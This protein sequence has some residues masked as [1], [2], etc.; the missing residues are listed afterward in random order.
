MVA[1]FN[2]VEPHQPNLDLNSD[3]VDFRYIFW[4]MKADLSYLP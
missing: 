2:T 1:S 4:N 3:Y